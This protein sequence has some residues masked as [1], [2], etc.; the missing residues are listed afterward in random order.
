MAKILIHKN[1]LYNN[2][3]ILS[4]HLKDGN[5]LAVV[6]KDNAYGHGLKE[7]AKLCSDFGVKKAVVRHHYEAETIKDL[8]EKIIVLG[9]CIT[10]PIKNG[11]YA[12]NKLEDIAIPPKGSM[13]ELKVDT[14]MHRNGISM[15]DIPKAIEMLTQRGLVLAGVF[16]HNRSADDLSSE[17]FWQQQNFETVK[18]VVTGLMKKQDTPKFHSLSSS[19]IFRKQQI[20]DDFVRAGIAIYGYLEW[21]DIFG[22]IGL[23]PV[24]EL[25]AEKIASLQLKK[26]QKMGYSGIGIVKR[27]G[28]VSSYDIGYG[29]G[30][31]RAS[32]HLKACIEDGREILGRVSM[33]CLSIV[34]NEQ[35]ITIFQDAKRFAK[36]FHTISYDV[37]TKLSPLLER[38][39]V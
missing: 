4:N 11:S 12:I 8:F 28:V 14:G 15:S 22:D 32:E 24:M 29:D 1:N 39:I 38:I 26:N 36:Q 16:T 23:K 34:G 30:L 9:G 19:G 20:T 35:E 18:S 21:D 7:I 33:D 31:L 2:L 27:D 13:V 37:T 10:T 17:F 25:K 6:L 3:Q 5:K